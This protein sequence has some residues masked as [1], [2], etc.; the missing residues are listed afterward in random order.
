[1]TIAEIDRR[2]KQRLENKLSNDVLQV[3]VRARRW[4]YRDWMTIKGWPLRTIVQ[5]FFRHDMGDR[6]WNPR[7]LP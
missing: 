7:R 6:I 5:A 4:A 3:S 1:M 2:K